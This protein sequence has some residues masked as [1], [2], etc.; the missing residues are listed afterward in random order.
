MLVVAANAQHAHLLQPVEWRK[1]RPFNGHARYRGGAGLV[2]SAGQDLAL[3]R[4]DLGRGHQGVLRQALGDLGQQHR[5]GRVGA[6][7]QGLFDRPGQ[8]V[9]GAAAAGQ[10]PFVA[11]P[12]GQQAG[13]CG[14]QEC[15]DD[16]GDHEA[17][18]QAAPARQTGPGGVGAHSLIT[19]SVRNCLSAGS[20]DS[21]PSAFGLRFTAS[22]TA[23]SSGSSW[24]GMFW[25]ENI[26]RD[27]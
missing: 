24:G 16:H 18:L 6:H 14:E 3:R 20:F 4:P 8:V 10:R 1:K 19:S 23:A 11:Q 7:G 21:Q 26:S 25:P 12:I 5:V 2:C 22:I 17:D 27:Q 13:Q 15:P 9:D